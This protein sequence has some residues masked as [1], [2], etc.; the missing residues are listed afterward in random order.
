MGEDAHY[1][2]LRILHRRADSG[3]SYASRRPRRNRADHIAAL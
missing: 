1:S 2:A 3:L